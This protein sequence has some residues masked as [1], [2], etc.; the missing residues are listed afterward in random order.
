MAAV[1]CSST[2]EAEYDPATLDAY[3]SALP[4][5]SRLSADAPD[6]EVGSPGALTYGNVAALAVE[7][8]RFARSI[9]APAVALVRALRAIVRQPPSLYDS[10]KREFL[11]GPWD[12]EDG[13]GKVSLYIR[14]NEVAADF[15]YTYALVRMVDGDL[16]EATP[17][18]WGAATPDPEDEQKSV[19]ISLWDVEANKAF[20]REHDPAFDGDAQNGSGR[21]VMLYGHHEQGQREALFNVA[22]FRNFVPDDAEIG[23]SPADLDYFYGRVLEPGGTRVDFFDSEIST[24]LCDAT[25]D[26][27]FENDT[28]ADAAES[29]EFLAVFVDGGLG[30]AEATVHEGDLSAPVNLVECWDASFARTFIQL[31]SSGSTVLQNGACAAPMDQGMS[32]LG[33]PSLS[34]ID[35]D[36]LSA[37]D[38]VAQHGTDSCSLQ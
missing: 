8:A 9:N 11:W 26:S 33:L 12:N 1:A 20:E 22:V 35:T 23:E 24:D 2:P 37:L 18:I 13:F 6:A 29:L 32:S 5:Q 31:E 21:F 7:S 10:S 19:G 27:C 30:R 4:E 38:C 25:A 28:T 16:A 3:L 17:V 36:L 14:E 34:T 15:R